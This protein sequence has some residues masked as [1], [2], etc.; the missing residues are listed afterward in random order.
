LS[1]ARRINYDDFSSSSSGWDVFSDPLGSVGY[2][3]G[4]YFIE[5]ENRFFVGIW[6]EAELQ[7]DVI[8]QVKALGPI[9]AWISAGAGSQGIVFDWKLN[10]KGISYAFF[11]DMFGQCGFMKS[12]NMAGYKDVALGYYSNFGDPQ[13]Y[14]LLS[15]WIHGGEAVGFV[16]DTY[17]ATALLAD[18]VPGKVGLGMSPNGSGTMKAYFDDFSIYKPAQ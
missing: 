16:D 11:I 15:V 9:S 14:Y 18:R 3:D 13:R 5:T 12:E 2:E 8:L 10:W 7:D 6:E 4:R 1:T 17:C